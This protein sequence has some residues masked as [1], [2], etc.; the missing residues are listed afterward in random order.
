MG[1]RADGYATGRARR[2]R[3]IDAAIEAFG[4]SGFHNATLAD[5]AEACGIS[6]P[7]LLHHF[8]SKE[9]LLTAVLERRDAVDRAAFDAAVAASTSPLQALVD[10]T[11]EN[12]RTG[13]LMALYA[14]LSAEATNPRHP[15]HD[16]F[17]QLYRTLAE[18]LGSALEG[19]QRA[20][21]LDPAVHPSALAR[22]LLALKDGLSL[23]ALLNPDAVD[24][25][26]ALAA[27]IRRLTGVE[28][29]P[30]R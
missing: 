13:G 26:T 20:G 21:R 17:A 10:M 5:I 23:Q 12:A 2:E 15:A 11:A 7:G 25:A 27:A 8:D 6:R 22:E 9:A 4:Q 28:L 29:T 16:Y 1:T 18:D 30:P 14:M 24:A 19:M 3:I